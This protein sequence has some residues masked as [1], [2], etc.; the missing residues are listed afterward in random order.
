MERF[1][2]AE[3]ISPQL[4]QSRGQKKRCKSKHLEQNGS[5]KRLKVTHGDRCVQG[6]DLR[7]KEPEQRLTQEEELALK[8][9]L[10]T[11]KETRVVNCRK[12]SRDKCPLRSK[13]TAAAN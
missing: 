11:H 8:L 12:G 5:V 6:L 10:T 7:W 4:P 1:R 13:S 3:N 9:Q 2:A